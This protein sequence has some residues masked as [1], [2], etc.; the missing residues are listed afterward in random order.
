MKKFFS[1]MFAA[2]AMFMFTACDKTD[3]M[4]DEELEAA[5]IDH[6][7]YTGQ[8]KSDDED[9][10]DIWL[11][12]NFNADKTYAIYWG[13]KRKDVRKDDADVLLAGKWKVLDGKLLM[14]DY[15][16][17]VEEWFGAWTLSKS[18]KRISYSGPS[19]SVELD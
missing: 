10:D 11:S 14:T 7:Q 2:A 15:D 12:A 1:L 5:I 8:T 16:D 13:E 19:F 17:E 6:A 18:G 9:Y 3:D 4:T